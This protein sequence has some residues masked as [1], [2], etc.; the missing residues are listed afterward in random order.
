M[1][2]RHSW[3][4][5]A[6]PRGLAPSV[7]TLAAHVHRVRHRPAARRAAQRRRDSTVL[8]TYERRLIRDLFGEDDRRPAKGKVGPASG[9]VMLV[10]RG[11]GAISGD[12]RAD[13]NG[14]VDGN[15]IEMEE[16]LARGAFTA[17]PVSL[18]ARFRRPGHGGRAACGGRR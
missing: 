14:A 8:A 15:V 3:A 7:V 2:K 13:P 1:D 11:H 6:M 18:A 12:E 4:G 17:C 10:D 16:R 5:S 9:A